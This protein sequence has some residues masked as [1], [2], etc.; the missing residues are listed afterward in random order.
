[1]LNLHSKTSFLPSLFQAVETALNALKS[2]NTEAF[3]RKQA[4]EVIK[5]FLVSTMNLDDDKQTL[6]HLFTHPSF[7]DK[8]IPGHP[9]PLYKF[10][11]P[12]VRR[13][14]E[15]ALT[16]MFGKRSEFQA[17]DRLFFYFNIISMALYMHIIFQ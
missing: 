3:Y 4:W 15:Q 9:G 16:G 7:T 17:Y 5:G 1:M 2:S 6:T 8:D 13:V 12:H 11:D 14:Q 10:S